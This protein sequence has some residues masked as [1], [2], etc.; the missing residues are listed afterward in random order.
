[1]TTERVLFLLIASFT[2]VSA[3]MVVQ[4]RRLIH[5][6]FWLIATLL[7]VAI[8]YAFLQATFLVVVQIAIYVGAIAV[9]FIFAVMLTQRPAREGEAR[10]RGRSGLALVISLCLLGSLLL[11]VFTLPQATRLPPA[12][13]ADLNAVQALGVALLSPSR[14]DSQAL[15]ISKG[16]ALPFEVASVLLLAALIGAVYAA[17]SERGGKSA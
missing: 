16:Y 10:T 14:Y 12:M 7:G 4:A 15:P 8:L 17:V 2:L 9:L 3:I 1:M 11:L 13:P 6:A 5:A